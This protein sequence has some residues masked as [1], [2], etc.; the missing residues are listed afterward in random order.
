[1][2]EVSVVPEEEKK[3]KKS[4]DRS[5]Q[6]F[7]VPEGS[8]NSKLV[9]SSQNG[10][11]LQ[12]EVP[13][14]EEFSKEVKIYGPGSKITV[15][16]WHRIA[17]ASDRIC[18]VDYEG[19]GWMGFGVSNHGELLQLLDGLGIFADGEMRMHV[20]IDEGNKIKNLSTQHLDLIAEQMA[21]D[22]LDIVPAE[23]RI[24]KCRLSGNGSKEI[25]SDII[26][27]TKYRFEI[28][29]IKVFVKRRPIKLDD[30]EGQW[31]VWRKIPNFPENLKRDFS[32]NN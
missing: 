32:N 29:E 20:I 1:M 23:C 16:E 15:E 31:V 18:V 14:S 4:L 7:I 19:R 9:N 13:L 17:R 30:P 25:G 22:I 2:F 28:D 3:E 5:E 26:Q 27:H 8:K 6:G 21:Q 11:E 10:L 24:K 12:F